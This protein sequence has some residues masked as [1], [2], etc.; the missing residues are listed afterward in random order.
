M[1]K[2]MVSF[3][4]R[5][6]FKLSRQLRAISKV[7]DAQPG[8]FVR[9]ILEA[10]F[11]NGGLR[12]QL[13]QQRLNAAVAKWGDAP[14]HLGGPDSGTWTAPRKQGKVAVKGANRGKGPPMS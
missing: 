5:L 14:L 10:T 2:R 11:D 4:F 8:A 9:D 12:T 6:P 13:F 3:T 7:Y 1:K